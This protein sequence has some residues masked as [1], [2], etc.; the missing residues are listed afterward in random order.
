MRFRVDNY[1]NE[2]LML[3]ELNRFIH[4][5]TQMGEW[6]MNHIQLVRKYAFI[7]NDRLDA[8]LSKRKLG[9]IALA[10]DLFKERSLDPSKTDVQWEGHPI[11]QD[12]KRY[13]RTNLDTLEE[14]GLDEYFNSST[15]YH[16]LAAGI[17][18]ITEMGIKDPE[19]IYPVFFHS[20]PVMP[21]YETLPQRVKNSVDITMLADKLSSNWLRINMREVSVKVDLDLAVFGPNGNEFNYSLGLYLARLISEGKTT[22][23]VS[24]DATKYYFDRLCAINPLMS[25]NLSNKK[26][27]GSKKWPKR[28]SLAFKK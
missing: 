20:C 5:D 22:D 18:L 15:Q 28:P 12:T 24:A 11:L 7:L 4:A 26:L 19:I 6:H 1:D 2:N 10:H 8:Q 25:T 21:I 16:A 13:V 23:K 17:F 9:Y 14:F 3:L 27:G